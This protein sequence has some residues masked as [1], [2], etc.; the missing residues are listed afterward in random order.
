MERQQHLSSVNVD[1]GKDRA[2]DSF[3]DLTWLFNC[4]SRNRGIIR[5][6]FDEAAFL[7]KAVRATGGNILEVGRNQA[8]STVLL[9]AAAPGREIYSIDIKAKAHPACGKFLAR[10]ENQGRVHQLVADSRKTLPGLTFGFLFI[11][12]DHSFDGVLA[13]VIAHWNALEVSGLA[14]FHDAVPNQNFK[15]R[16]EHRALHRFW[17]RTKNRFRKA[18]KPE[19]APDYETGVFSVCETLVERGRA[20]RGEHAGSML[21]LR[22]LANLPADFE[23]IARRDFAQRQ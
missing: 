2:L 20:A 3:E 21:L 11:D 7:W 1:L 4:D 6:G 22:K 19:I 9:A 14:V 5:Q 8:G 17:I 12:G 23:T 10:P 16:D 13:D 18:K 15:W